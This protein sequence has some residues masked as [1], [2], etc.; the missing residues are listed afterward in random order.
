MDLNY[1]EMPSPQFS[2][3]RSLI[4]IW[5]EYCFLKENVEDFLN[6]NQI[7]I[8]FKKDDKIFGSNED[9]RITFAQLKNKEPDSD[10]NFLA[11]D[12]IQSLDREDPVNLLFGIKD[13]PH[14]KVCDKDEIIDLLMKKRKK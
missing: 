4:D 5:D 3:F 2:K 14:L 9:G 10:D 13:I 1:F 11:T 12:L 6:K 8:F 7:I